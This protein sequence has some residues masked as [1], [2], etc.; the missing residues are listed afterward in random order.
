[1]VKN[2]AGGGKGK[3]VARKHM[4]RRDNDLRVVENKDEKYGYVKK[5]L[6][7]SFDVLCDDGIERRC[8]IRGKFKGRNK[9]DNVIDAG[10][11]VLIGLR[12]WTNEENISKDQTKYCDL[13]EV[14]KK[15]EI[16]LLKKSYG[17]FENF[18]DTLVNTVDINEH[19]EWVDE[20]TFK[21]QNMTKQIEKQIED[22]G[23]QNVIITTKQKKLG[24]GIIIQ[25]YDISDSDSD[26]DNDLSNETSEEEEPEDEKEEEEEE[27]EQQPQNSKHSIKEVHRNN[28]KIKENEEE[29]VDVD[30]I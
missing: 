7:N 17:I 2:T 8:M 5:L 10:S 26:E 23:E 4:N 18:K 1:M 25:D 11:W 19:I 3:K 28:H 27:E 14:Y 21:Y 20:K 15:S 29:I 16:D 24:S 9:R 12:E 30:D 22:C 13:L 6:G